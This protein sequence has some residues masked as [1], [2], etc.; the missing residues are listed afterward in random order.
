MLGRIE[1]KASVRACDYDGLPGEVYGWHGR[2]VEELSNVHTEDVIESC[3][4]RMREVLLYQRRVQRKR[5]LC[6]V[7]LCIQDLLAM[8]AQLI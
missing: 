1:A 6:K 7:V 5:V 2:G 4:G 8:V 3:H